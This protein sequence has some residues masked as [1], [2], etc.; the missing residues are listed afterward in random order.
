MPND[1]PMRTGLRTIPLVLWVWSALLPA[2]GSLADTGPLAPPV[3]EGRWLRPATG[4][5]AEP[6]W[7]HARGLQ[8]GLA[9]LPGPRGLLRIYAPHLGLP[10]RQVINFIAVEPI[11][12]R[13]TH[14]DFSELESS[15]LDGRQGKRFWSADGPGDP[16]PRPPEMPARGIVTQEGGIEVLRVF[17]L[18]EPFESG[19]KPYVRL[20]FRSDRPEEVGIAA[21][22][23]KDSRPLAYC[24]VTA[25][26][27]NYARLRR[28][29]LK[30]GVV[31][32]GSLWP[33]FRGD[34]FAP[35]CVFSF[36]RLR[37]NVDGE[38]I[39]PATPDES[40]PQTTQYAPQ[41]PPWWRYRGP[42]A[43]QYWRAPGPNLDLA[44]RV[45]GRTTYWGTPC[46]IPGGIAYEN[47]ELMAP[48]YD[49]QEFWF[50]ATRRTP[51]E[52]GK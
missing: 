23:H 26:M 28:L 47:F 24:V 13:A 32:A 1:R 20:T 4:T 41:T 42:V 10:Q 35:P 38:V 9:P 29:H 25:T 39:V 7:G 51:Q 48:H 46:P 11:V 49:G 50:G 22:A 16:T 19:A 34:G 40:N 6:L 12:D 2:D 21:Y 8:V 27:G 45:N 14:R 43:T 17:V 36:D 44:V 18:V 31:A 33:D 52:L 5:A 3:V 30:D 37:R 15:R